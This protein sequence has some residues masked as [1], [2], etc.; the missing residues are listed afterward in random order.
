[1]SITLSIYTLRLADPPRYTKRSVMHIA[2]RETSLYNMAQG[3]CV[4]LYDLF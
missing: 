1:M 4:W 3:P 2:G